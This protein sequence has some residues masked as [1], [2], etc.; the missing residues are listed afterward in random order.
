M[1]RSALIESRNLDLPPDWDFIRQV[2]PV[3]DLAMPVGYIIKGP[4]LAAEGLDLLERCPRQLVDAMTTGLA[5]HPR[6][7]LRI[8]L[9]RSAWRRADALCRK[10]SQSGDG[11]AGRSVRWTARRVLL[12]AI[13]I[14]AGRPDVRS[15]DTTASAGPP[16]NS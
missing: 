15:A 9:D 5:M 6:S 7:G 8:P 14:R 16:L 13:Y 3:L 1:T 4:K 12:C 10:W 11:D 2:A